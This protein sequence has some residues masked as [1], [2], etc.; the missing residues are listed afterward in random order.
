[1]GATV[2]R[3]NF[4]KIFLDILRAIFRP[5]PP[6]PPPEP[7]PEPEP[8]PPPPPVPEPIPNPPYGRRGVVRTEGRAF[9]DDGGQFNAIGATLFWA[10]WGERHDPDRLEY[11]NLAIVAPRVD[12]IRI[13]A[14]VGSESWRDRVI[15]PNAPDY[16]D[17]VDRLFARLRR[18]GLRAQVTVFA[19][20]QV[21]MPNR[22]DQVVFATEWATR[23]RERYRTQVM[24]VEVA[25]EYW[26]N[27]VG[28]EDLYVL[29]DIL[30][31]SGVP[32]ALSAPTEDD[33]CGIY[34]LWDGI[35]TLHYD[36]DISK[37]DG[38][39][40]PIRQP[41]GYSSEYME[42]ERYHGR[43]PD[44]AVNNEPIGPESSVASEDNPARIAL[45]A[46]ATFIAGNAAYCFHAGA[47]IRGGGIGDLER[48]R[49][50]NLDEYSRD[51]W[52]GLHNVR[53]TVRDGIANGRRENA[54]WSTMPWDGSQTAVERGALV[55][56]YASI[57]NGVS[58]TAVFIGTKQ[59][60]DIT[61]RHRMSFSV[62]DPI[63]G[64]FVVIANKADA[65]TVV[66]IPG[67][68]EGLIL[69]G[70]IEG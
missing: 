29:G 8:E 28:R 21:M 64:D 51:F 70:V 69:F 14:M 49:K 13:L 62:I 12:Y 20:A 55:R 59:R 43:M 58:T 38:P 48:G 1:M 10:L 19:D 5:S 27:G 6:P 15:D 3:I 68:H 33:V 37:S 65:G 2:T 24:F 23:I 60:H 63:S 30:Q 34:G 54:Q 67:G 36:R 39:Y 11:R 56:A 57:V 50:S 52:A 32:V 22:G 41:W 44:V 4:R 45:A 18:H 16:W 35:A 46:A 26:Q 42:R 53:L 9:A 47:G 66:T 17:V 7:D 31:T 61:L 40:R 25:N